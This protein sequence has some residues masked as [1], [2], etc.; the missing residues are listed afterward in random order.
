MTID[1]ED[2]QQLLA[3]VDRFARQ[4]IAVATARPEAP[5]SPSTMH[6]L[7]QEAH[8]LGLLPRAHGEEGF[9]LWEH[10]HSPHAQAF[11]TG[12][13][14]RVARANAGLAFAW[15]RA[16]LASAVVRELGC[17]G[18]A[19]DGLACT[20]LTTGHYG[21]A[22]T[23]LARWF[24]STGTGTGTG[25]P[26]SADPDTDDTAML[27]DWL[28]RRDHD[29]VLVAPQAWQTLLWPVWLQGEVRWQTLDR[30]QLQV[31]PFPGQHGLDEMMAY[32]VR[33]SVPT[34]IPI[35]EPIAC[36]PE[37]SRQIYQRVLKMDMLGLLAIGHGALLH[38]QALATAYAGV[39]KQGGKPIDQHPAVQQLLAEIDMARQQAELALSGMAGPIDTIDLG[40]VCATRISTHQALCNAANQV[41]QV[42]GGSGYMRDTGAEKIVRDQNMLKLQIGGT[43]DAP[44]FVAGWIGGG[45]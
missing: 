27:S 16:A 12:L 28:N 37:R 45:V 33:A 26:A 38:G 30:A 17:T 40:N 11:N 29:S 9:A 21:L 25:T 5:I 6:A 43:R 1:L 10:L 34:R 39:R 13:L 8:D 23:S 20:L 2:T 42:H 14:S 32:T 31:A 3:E 4:R 44:L 24:K 19:H 7:T 22:R 36:G 18:S 41:I 35:S 15:H